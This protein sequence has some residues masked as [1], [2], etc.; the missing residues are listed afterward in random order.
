[1][2]RN[3]LRSEGKK[4][5]IMA[6]MK[7]PKTKTILVYGI[8]TILAL[9]ISVISG[10]APSAYA[11]RAADEKA[12]VYCEE[13]VRGAGALSPKSIEA[14]KK[15][16]VAGYDGGNKTTTCK[17]YSGDFKSMCENSYAKG[18]EAKAKL[19]ETDGREGAAAKK[20]K[21]ETCKKY[22]N[23]A[24]KA[25]CQKAYDNQII[26]MA[27]IAGRNAGRSGASSP[28]DRLGYGGS[29]AKSACKSSYTKGQNEAGRN[30]RGTCG[31]VDTYFDYG[32]ICEGTNKEAG[33]NQSPI[34]A[35]ALGVVG[36]I[37]ALVAVAVVGGIMYGGFLYLSAR[38][39]AGQTEKGVTVI[40]N[41]VV[42]LVVWVFAYALINFLVPGGL[43]NG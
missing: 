22:N 28:C 35:L 34:I 27:Q 43:F 7:T 14:C 23:A 37:T 16:Y 11:S 20:S 21:T 12:K 1:M 33:G 3:Y 36:W 6:Y 29:A 40:T 18:R 25:T 13:D 26:A 41:A 10:Q 17:G 30:A 42:A 5:I 24:N 9:G 38:D 2:Y 31:G 39:N 8:I 4:C 32:K 19:P 15:G